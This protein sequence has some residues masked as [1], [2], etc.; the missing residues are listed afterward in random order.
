[1][2][3]DATPME[4]I[5]TAVLD[6]EFGLREQGYSSLVVVALGYRNAKE[7]YNAALPKSRLPLNEIITEV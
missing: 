2:G 4:G 7:D 3:L 1:M 5:E 6:E